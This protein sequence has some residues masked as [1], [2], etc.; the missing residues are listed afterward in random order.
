MDDLAITRFAWQQN[1]N[2]LSVLSVFG[3]VGKLVALALLMMRLS[4]EALFFRA[5]GPVRGIQKLSEEGLAP[6]G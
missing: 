4:F 3:R 2:E 5:S 6:A 1:R